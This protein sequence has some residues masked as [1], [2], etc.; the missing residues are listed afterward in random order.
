VGAEYARV[1]FALP[2]L[3]SLNENLEAKKVSFTV[4]FKKLRETEV[5]S[6]VLAQAK[7]FKGDL[8]IF[9]ENNKARLVFDRA[10]FQQ[11]MQIILQWVRNLEE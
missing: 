5:R 9:V 7:T 2:F 8:A 10:T 4:T 11:Y 1:N 3:K 6:K